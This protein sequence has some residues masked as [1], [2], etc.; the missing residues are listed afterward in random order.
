[1]FYE[2]RSGEQGGK[3][4]LQG[5]RLL[6]RAGWNALLAGYLSPL[7]QRELRQRELAAA[8]SAVQGLAAQVPRE[9]R[10]PPAQPVPARHSGQPALRS[11]LRR[12]A[13]GQ[14]A[15]SRGPATGGDYSAG[16]DRWTLPSRSMP[17]LWLTRP[18][19]IVEPA[20]V[21]PLPPLRWI[22]GVAPSGQVPHRPHEKLFPMP[23]STTYMA[24]ILMTKAT[25][26]AMRPF[27]RIER[28]AGRG[29]Y[30]NQPTPAL[31]RPMKLSCRSG[32]SGSVEASPAANTW[33][34][35]T[36]GVPCPAALFTNPNLCS[37]RRLW[38]RVG[39]YLAL[40]LLD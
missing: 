37:L 12:S 31:M 19:P 9:P 27:T 4:L 8:G 22:P 38:L 24:P 35:L 30:E 5:S 11:D 13:A 36:T 15:G 34:P 14:A 7:H 2:V 23:R 33:L 28:R 17:P 39:P 10:A 40:D 25:A 18:P 29:R 20:P 1:M 16:R 3:R 32:R 6:F 26:V 21:P